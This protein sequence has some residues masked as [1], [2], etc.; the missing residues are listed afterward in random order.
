M[1]ESIQ[2][3]VVASW[4]PSMEAYAQRSVEGGTLTWNVG[5]E[6]LISGNLFYFTVLILLWVFLKDEKKGL[7]PKLFMKLYNLSCVI[8]A[9][10]ALYYIL[11]YIA[12]NGIKFVGNQGL[13]DTPD[14]KLLLQT[15]T[16]YFYYQKYWEFLDTFIFMARKSYRQVSFLHVYHHCS[17]TLI[18]ALYA[19]F[20]QSGDLFLPV[21]LNSFVHVLMYSHYFLSAETPYIPITWKN[22]PWKPYLTSLQLIQFLLIASQSFLSWFQGPEYGFPDWMKL[23]MIGYMGTMLILFGKFFVAS[24]MTPKKPSAKKSA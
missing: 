17:I 3:R 12:R 14:G 16:Y 8:L 5:I 11:V 22:A 18:V 20:D 9:G 1:F 24:Y 10:T 4:A 23:V 21:A 19:T 7:D 13:M 6:F 2:E 15:A